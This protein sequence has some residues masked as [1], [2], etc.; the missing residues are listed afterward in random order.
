MVRKRKMGSVSIRNKK[1]YSPNMP[2]RCG[3]YLASVPDFTENQEKSQNPE[4]K[5]Y[6]AEENPE[7]GVEPEYAWD[8][9]QA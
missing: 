9:Y 8:P 6:Y 2:K 1:G 7:V 5:Q 4:G 3:Y